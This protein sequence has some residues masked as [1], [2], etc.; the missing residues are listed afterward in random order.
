MIFNLGGMTSTQI[1]Q[2]PESS[3]HIT[4]ID[5]ETKALKQSARILYLGRWTDSIVALSL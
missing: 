1:P 2:I 5:E 3:N 4:S